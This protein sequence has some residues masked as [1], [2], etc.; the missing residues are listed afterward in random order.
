MENEKSQSPASIA[1]TQADRGALLVHPD[2][3]ESDVAWRSAR[4]FTAEE[5][6][7]DTPAAA[8]AWM[9]ELPR[10]NP[11][12]PA[13]LSLK[14]ELELVAASGR[15]SESDRE[16][17][18]ELAQWLTVWLQNPQIFP[19]WFALR[20]NTAEFRQLFGS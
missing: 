20:R 4:L 8:V 15:T 9:E 6:N 7:F 12:R 17:A 1:R 11:P 13:I 5:L 18:G 16:L 14:R 3:L 19:D 10:R 2:V